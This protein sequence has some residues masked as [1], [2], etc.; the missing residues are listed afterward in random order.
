LRKILDTR[1]K[2]ALNPKA[3]EPGVIESLQEDEQEVVD[4]SRA[5]MV[6][7]FNATLGLN[8]G[9]R[10]ALEGDDQMAAAIEN[11]DQATEFW[12]AFVE[13]LE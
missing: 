3:I 2:K 11:L 12:E 7:V 9:Y 10:V 13:E 1:V 6:E 4:V 5:I 8:E